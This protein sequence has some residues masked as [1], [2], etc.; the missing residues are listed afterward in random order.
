MRITLSLVLFFFMMQLNA[1]AQKTAPK[2]VV[3][4]K[5]KNNIQLKSN[6]FK[7]AEAYLTFDDGTPVPADNKV[8]VDQKINMVLI[9]DQGW[10]VTDSLV[11][12]GASEKI[13]LNTG[14]TILK[15]DDFFTA[16]DATGVSPADARYIT[17]K[18][19]I[20]RLDDKKKYIIVNFKVWDK[21]GTSTVTGSYKFF[22]K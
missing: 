21:K 18:A 14:Y 8:E 3:K 19:V 16:Y 7:I 2:T 6:G 11:Y 20:T 12:P 5:I 9:I 17:L 13:S 10:K 1:P 15:E 4:T 22:I